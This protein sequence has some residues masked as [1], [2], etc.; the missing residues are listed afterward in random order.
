VEPDAL[1]FGEL[2]VGDSSELQSVTVTNTGTAR[3]VISS[4]RF[5]GPAAGEFVVTDT[6][7]CAEELEVAP[8]NTCTIDV[9]F[10]PDADGERS[11]SLE[12][13]TRGGLGAR[14]DLVGTGQAPPP[15][16]TGET[17]TTA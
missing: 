17:E 11:A 7:T 14:V 3:F 6:G 12:I 4:L 2:E 9:V 1:E 8:G 16:N 13:E 5:A 10:A 15:A